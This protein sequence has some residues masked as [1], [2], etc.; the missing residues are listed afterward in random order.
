MKIKKQIVAKQ[1]EPTQLVLNNTANYNATINNSFNDITMG[2]INILFEYIYTITENNNLKNKKYYPF[3]FKR[4]LETLIHIYALLLYY[5]KNVELTM[6][7]TKYAL[8]EYI[9][10]VD[11]MTDDKV[12]FLQLTSRDAV[13]FVYKK[14]IFEVNN[15]YRKSIKDPN[16]EDKTIFNNLNTYT[17]VCKNIILFISNH[18]AFDKPTINECY[19]CVK[20]IGDNISKIKTELTNYISVFSIVL[21]DIKSRNPH[22]LQV[23]EYLDLMNQF[24]KM[25]GKKKLNENFKNNIYDFEIVNSN[26]KIGDIIDFIFTD[27]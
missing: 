27:N 24:T 6:H 2:F 13:L 25:I 9:E 12:T 5:T 18:S 17:A 22:M 11:Q 21:N 8:Y 20:N 4:G 10:F 19:N 26:G 16:G 3:I 15:E 23:N 7:H 14:S 1:N